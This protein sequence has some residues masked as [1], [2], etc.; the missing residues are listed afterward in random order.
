MK[1]CPPEDQIRAE[2]SSAEAIKKKFHHKKIKLDDLLAFSK[3]LVTLLEAGVLLLKS[4]NVIIEQIESEQLFKVVTQLKKDVEQG[5][6]FSEA[7]AEHPKVFDSFWVSLV[8][9]GE[10]AG[11]MPKVLTKLTFYLEQQASFRSTIISAV[12]YPMILFVI[13]LGA[14]TFFALFVGPRFESVF[15]SMNVEL[16][17]ITKVLLGLFRAIKQNFLLLFSRNRGRD[18]FYCDS[19]PKLLSAEFKPKHFF[20]DYQR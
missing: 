16:P 19:T 4:L 20:S 14:V 15:N 8:E 7:L 6:S 11:T 13:C 3:Q 12:M 5:K 18:I 10:A 17:L 2:A 9:V 1:Q